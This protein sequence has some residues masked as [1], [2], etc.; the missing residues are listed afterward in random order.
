MDG[1]AG[2]CGPPASGWRGRPSRD[3]SAHVLFTADFHGGDGSMGEGRDLWGYYLERG[4][5]G[6]WHITDA[7]VV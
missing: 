2:R 6:R 1:S 7:G 5:D 3:A 4:S